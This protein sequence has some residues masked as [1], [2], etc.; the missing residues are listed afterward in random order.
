MMIAMD[1]MLWSLD[2]ENDNMQRNIER[3][4]EYMDALQ[5]RYDVRLLLTVDEQIHRLELNMKIRHESFLLL[6]ELMVAMVQ[7]GASEC[8]ILINLEKSNLQFVMQFENAGSDMGAPT[9]LLER[10]D[11]QKRLESIHGVLDAQV[12]KTHSIFILLVPVD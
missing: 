7:A 3:M 8:K 10:T 12:H 11:M 6:K 2:P 5:Q 4:Q 1:D 9:K